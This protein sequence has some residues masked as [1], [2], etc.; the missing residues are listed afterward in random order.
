MASNNWLCIKDYHPVTNLSAPQTLC[1]AKAMYKP[2]NPTSKSDDGSEKKP[3]KWPDRA[4]TR[5]S[6]EGGGF[7]ERLEGEKWGVN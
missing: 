5:R 1:F 2:L 7:V 6:V 4:G 3:K